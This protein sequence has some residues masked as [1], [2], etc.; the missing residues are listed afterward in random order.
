M[1]VYESDKLT[2]SIK[3]K[4]K[5]GILADGANRGPDR[6]STPSRACGVVAHVDDAHACLHQCDRAAEPSGAPPG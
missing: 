1:H 4:M 2:A 6:I 5:L 3:F